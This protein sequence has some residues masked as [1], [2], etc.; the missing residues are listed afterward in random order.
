MTDKVPRFL[1]KRKLFNRLNAFYIQRLSVDRGRKR[2]EF[3]KKN[4]LP[5]IGTTQQTRQL[6]LDVSVIV[7]NDAG[8]GIQRVVREIWSGLERNISQTPDFILMP[9]YATRKNKYRYLGVG[10]VPSEFDCTVEANR[11]DVFF[12]LDWSANIVTSNHMDLFN[13]K[14]QGVVL[15]FVLYDMLPFLNKEWFTPQTRKKFIK[16]LELISKYADN[17]F[18]I[19]DVVKND[20]QAW[21]YEKMDTSA[22]KPQL[23]NVPL[24]VNLSLSNKATVANSP[25]HLKEVLANEYVLMVG[26]LEPRKSH[27]EV[28]D[29]FDVLWGKGS[30]M[31][32]VFVGRPGWH[33]EDLQNRINNHPC[34]MKKLFWFNNADDFLLHTLYKHSTGV[35]VASKGEGF[36]LPLIEALSYNKKV[37]AR[38]LPVFKEIAGASINYFD[39]H[40]PLLLSNAIEIWLQSSGSEGAS[41]KI[42]SW[43]SV[44]LV[45]LD[46]VKKTLL[47]MS[48]K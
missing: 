16:W 36:G 30:G 48:L 42:S 9:I 27:Q 19:S 44:S 24:G 12:G 4:K 13:W 25:A 11:G 3:L 34:N 37:L 23:H 39:N 22:G 31:S 41:K 29:A 43:D 21:I 18:C 33:T 47:P 7:Q 2:I 5:N 10:G 40:N 6:L 26:T 15:N 28:L 32:L 17:I 8:T 1:Y 46:A 35:V 38:N 20:F 14:M 45:W